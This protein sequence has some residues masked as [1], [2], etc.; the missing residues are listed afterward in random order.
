M[1]QRA[2]IL[3]TIV[4]LLIFSVAG[5][6]QEKVDLDMV[7]RIRYE[8]F[9]NSKVME[10][11]SGLMDGIGPRLTGSPNAKR[12]NEWT[13]GQLSTMGLSDAHL[14]SWGPFGRGWSNEYISVRMVS[15]DIAPLI[16]YARAWTPGT[17]GTVKGKCVRVK[18]E[19]KKDFAKY[20][21]QLAGVIALFGP[22]PEVKT[23][24][25]PMFVR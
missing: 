21:G 20:K 22:G 4:P 15:P 3:L 7:S 5:W 16:A 25:Q 19:D 11:A 23:L 24:A 12:A 13:R 10:F 14:E 8:G 9:R 17:N 2:R 18:I 6:S 1:S